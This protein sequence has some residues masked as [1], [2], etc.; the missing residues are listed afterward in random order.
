MA[1]DDEDA[2]EDQVVFDSNEVISLVEA[3][4]KK[5]TPS[6]S[7]QICECAGRSVCCPCASTLIIRILME[8]RR[9]PRVRRPSP[10][11]TD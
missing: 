2:G 10:S 1:R 9:A 6:P 11:H 5:W 7:N 3:F 8:Q 4:L